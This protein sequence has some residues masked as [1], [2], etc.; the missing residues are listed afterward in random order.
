MAQ[1]TP[2]LGTLAMFAAVVLM[3]GSSCAPVEHDEIFV[4]G[5]PVERVVINLQSGSLVLT[6]ADTDEILVERRV[7]GWKGS[8]ELQTRAED[9]VLTL[10]AAC[11]GPLSCTVDSELELPPGLEVSVVLGDGRVEL[12][13]LSGVVDLSL[14]SGE[15]VGHGLRSPELA[16]QVADGPVALSF[17]EEVERLTLAMG[18]GD[19]ALQLPEGMDES[20]IEAQIARGELLITR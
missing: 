16:V 12:D 6:E 18:S 11:L 1:H 10:D 20:A 4:V 2:T 14:R 3:G 19:V 17:D 13:G 9:G 8:I 15:V 5:E 7:Q